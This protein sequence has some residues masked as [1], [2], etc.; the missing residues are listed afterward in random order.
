MHSGSHSFHPDDFSKT[1]LS[2]TFEMLSKPLDIAMEQAS[3]PKKEQNISRFYQNFRPYILEESR[4]IIANGLEKVDQYYTEQLSKKGKNKSLNEARPFNLVLKKLARLP[5]NEG[6]PLSMTFSGMI[7]KDIEHGSSMIV[8][9]LTTKGIE[10]KMSFIALGW[11]DQNSSELCVKIII[12]SSDY[13]DY[14]KCFGAKCSW[15]AHYLGSVISEQRMYDA[16]LEATDIPCVQQIVRAQIQDYS[17]TKI[18]ALVEA[19]RLN[20][21]QKKAIC[22]F[23]N[24]KNGST[25][26][27]QG[28]PG[29]GKTTTLVCLL[30]QVVAQKK[31]TMVSAHSNKGVQ[32]LALRTLEQMPDV[33]M[34]LLGVESKLNDTLRP[35]FLDGWY[36]TIYSHLSVHLEQIEQLAEKPT[37]RIGLSMKDFIAEIGQRIHLIQQM[38]IPFNLIYSHSLSKPAKEALQ[39]LTHDPFV[40]SDFQHLENI[41]DKLKREPRFKENWT[42]L[43]DILNRLIGKWKS[44][45]EEELKSYLLDHALIVFSTL[46]TAGRKSMLTMAPIDYLL[47]DEA[48]QSVEAATLIPMRFQPKKVLLV[49]DTKQLPAT[50]ISTALDDTD[51]SGER[52]PC[53]YQRSMMMR[54]EENQQPSLMLT[55]QYRMHP[56]IC[57]W[58]SDQYYENKLITAPAILPMQL[59]SET[60]LLSRP[61]A[62]YNVFGQAEK[63]NASHSVYNTKEA[64]YVMKI[65]EDI[66]RQHQHCSIGIVTPFTAQKQLI[67]ESLAQRK[68]LLPLVDVNTVDGFQGDERD[69]IIISFTRT[70][71]SEF[72][73]EFRRLNVA[74]TRAKACLIIVCAPTL[75][76]NDIGKLMANARLR[77][78]LH[79]EQDLNVI[80]TRGILP[81]ITQPSARIGLQSSA[82]QGNS[83]DQFNYAKNMEAADKAMAFVWYRRA[84]ENN[85]PQAQYHVSQCYLSGDL[86][87]AQDIQLSFDWLCKAAEQKLPSAQHALGQHFIS[88]QLIKKNVAA[89]MAYCEQAAKV[90]LV[91]AIV[92]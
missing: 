64:Q 65:I 8:L 86:L 16:C 61:Y 78:V 89:G 72:L 35:I 79:S 60:G 77:K 31:R 88:G 92:F 55:I 62:V 85:H 23:L 22:A 69:V 36:D 20:Q 87:V 91:E 14:A 25:L 39:A 34:I 33:P 26:L 18:T 49:G 90:G 15:Q 80:L 82:W 17:A 28:P 56:D 43:R 3:L 10:P 63:R 52:S 6:N 41:I 37:S 73:K 7:P 40:I 57:Q 83:N 75:L 45:K 1:V 19:N 2:W 5:K 29:T 54:L 48:A 27:L 4:A 9:L 38:L 44:I 59:L 76:S 71:V 46:I 53:H 30:K 74:I 70:H 13:D 66:R 58:P 50:V 12:S 47:V 84:A 11:E 81:V 42:T 32:V 67:N 68:H 24:A 51:R 21:S